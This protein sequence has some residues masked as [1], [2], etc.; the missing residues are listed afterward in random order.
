MR[1]FDP[2]RVQQSCRIVRHIFQGVRDAW[3]LALRHLGRHLDDIGRSGCR[4]FATTLR[5]DSSHVALP[6]VVRF[7]DTL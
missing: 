2:N 3:L 5:R 4:T 6:G 1:L 7:L